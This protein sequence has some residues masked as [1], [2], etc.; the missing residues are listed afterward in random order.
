MIHTRK[1]RSNR[2]NKTN[3][4]NTRNKNNTK[5]RVFTKK[6]FSSGDGMLTTVWGAPQWHFL[7]TILHKHLVI[8]TQMPL[9]CS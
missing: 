7:H 4:S 2:T 1:N 6:H 9:N 8:I 5:K 3:K